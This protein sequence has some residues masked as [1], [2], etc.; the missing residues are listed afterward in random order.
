MYG[1]SKLKD[2]SKVT[3]LNILIHVFKGGYLL[4]ITLEATR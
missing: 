3:F 1:L 2:C 4:D